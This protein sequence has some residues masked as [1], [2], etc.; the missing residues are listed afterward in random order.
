MANTMG[1]RLCTLRKQKNLTQ[2][3]LAEAMGVS[4]Q[5]V[6]KW[7]NDLSCPDITMLPQL[8]DYFQVSIDSLLREESVRETPQVIPPKVRKPFEKLILKIRVEDKS[9]KVSLNFPLSFV[10]LALEMGM[11]SGMLNSMTGN[12]SALKNVDFAALLQMAEVGVIGK[13]I[14]VEEEDGALIN[15]F[16]E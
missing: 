5:A 15:I 1:N 10:K 12:M 8:A 7:E 14:E 13:L 6:S 16:I 11:E 2:D 3:Q 9:D 4:A